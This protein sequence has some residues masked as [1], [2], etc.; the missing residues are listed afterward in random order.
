MSISGRL[1]WMTLLVKSWTASKERS[2]SAL[3]LNSV[4][5]SS[6]LSGAYVVCSAKNARPTTAVKYTCTPLRG[7]CPAQEN[8]HIS[9][10]SLCVRRST[11][12]FVVGPFPGIHQCKHRLAQGDHGL[13]VLRHIMQIGAFR[14]R[15]GITYSCTTNY[16]T[17]SELR[18]KNIYSQIFTGLL[19]DGVWLSC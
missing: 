12:C 1:L 7:P 2:M 19:C 11:G 15:L 6:P 18:H 13:A 17:D 9:R 8:A 5:A 10:G 16:V 14:D 3:I 4:G